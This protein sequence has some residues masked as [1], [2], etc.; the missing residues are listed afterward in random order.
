[1]RRLAVASTALS[2]FACGFA[3][4]DAMSANPRIA[5]VQI[6]LRAHGFQPGPVDGLSG[7][8]HAGRSPRSSANRG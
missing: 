3:A 2:V 7:P 1:M 4:D 6:A 5:A 8:R